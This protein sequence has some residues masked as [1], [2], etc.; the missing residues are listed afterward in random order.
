MTAPVLS[1]RALPD[2]TVYQVRTGTSRGSYVVLVGHGYAEL[3][4]WPGRWMN[5]AAVSEALDKCLR[6]WDVP[7]AI[8]CVDWECE[9]P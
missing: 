2:G 9:Y 1:Q 5:H 3:A 4:M 8:G 7:R 6:W